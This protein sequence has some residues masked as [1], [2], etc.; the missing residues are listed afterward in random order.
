MGNSKLLADV[1]G[2]FAELGITPADADAIAQQVHYL[3]DS[4]A[5]QEEWAE[6]ASNATTGGECS[7]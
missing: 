5:D 3:F 1:A 6:K 7:C 4:L 2:I